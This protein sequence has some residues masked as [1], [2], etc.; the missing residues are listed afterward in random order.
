MTQQLQKYY[1]VGIVST[2]G[3]VQLGGSNGGFSQVIPTKVGRIA[4]PCR[5]LLVAITKQI[6]R[7]T[8]QSEA[9]P[10]LN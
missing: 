2:L 3:V 1:L 5:P 4:M 10:S 9:K 8:R 7:K 6:Q